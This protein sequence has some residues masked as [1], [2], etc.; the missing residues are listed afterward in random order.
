MYLSL[1]N[2]KSSVSHN[3][4]SK[5]CDYKTACGYIEKPYIMG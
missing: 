2:W 1:I 5:S 4:I 3:S